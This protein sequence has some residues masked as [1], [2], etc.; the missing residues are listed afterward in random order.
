MAENKVHEAAKILSERGAAKG[1]RARAR[2]LSAE[3]RRNI[4]MKAASARWGVPRAVHDGEIHVGDKAIPCAVL[5]DGT[6][7]LTQEG[8]LKAIGRSGKPAAGR[9]SSVEKVA[10]FLALDSLKPF[11]DEELATSTK[12]LIF[13]T[14]TGGRAF[15][16]KAEL[17]P[18]VCEVYLQAR[19]EG[20]L[21]RNQLRF[22][23][24][25]DILMRGLAHVGIIALVDEA[26]GYQKVRDREA[27]QAILEKFIRK[28]LAAWVQRFPQEFYH[29]IYRLK[30]WNWPAM[31]KNRYSVVGKYT[32]D[33]VYERLAPKV[34]EELEA[35]NPKDHKGKRKAKH[36]QWLTDDMGIPA[37][38]QHLFALMALARAT[39]TWDA[40][41][42]LV[43][44]ALPKRDS[45]LLLPFPG[46]DLEVIEIGRGR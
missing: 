13:Q 11:V 5:E 45:N 29:E 19:D 44:R 24:A 7:L 6:R 3:E 22:A 35:R 27:L 17:L 16:Y 38:S 34:L 18:K 1:G 10:P 28:E 2:S 12:P 46:D 40:F 37:L 25:C 43:D 14:V 31:G 8:F 15:G 39:D 26:T 41:K 23:Q 32:I 21:M 20:V 30:G 36:H 33:L 42:R 4:A 9:G